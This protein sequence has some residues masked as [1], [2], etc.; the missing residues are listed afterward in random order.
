[1]SRLRGKIRQRIFQAAR[2]QCEYCRSPQDF[3]LA[4]LELDHIRPKG[5]E[6]KTVDD[7]LSAICRKCNE[8]KGMQTE[9]VDPQTGE[10]APLYNPRIQAWSDHFEFS[11]DG[12]FI[13]GKTAIGRATV[14]ALQL[15]RRRAVLLRRMWRK[16]GWHPPRE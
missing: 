12:S 11:F 8:L 4:D 5:K 3:L 7:N 14:E 6:G 15:N 13:M 16:A 2:F 10:T 9:A 1:M